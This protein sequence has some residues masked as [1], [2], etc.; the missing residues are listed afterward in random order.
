[1]GLIHPSDDGARAALRPPDELPE[2]HSALAW[3]DRPG[4]ASTT[5]SAPNHDARTVD[6]SST[7]PP[8]GMKLEPPTAWNRAAHQAAGKPVSSAMQMASSTLISLVM[9]LSLLAAA[10][11]LVPSLVEDIRYRWYRGQLR[12][13]YELTDE[14]MRHVAPTPGRRLSDGRRC[15]RPAWCISICSAICKR[16]VSTNASWAAATLHS[17]MKG[18][19]AGS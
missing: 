14:R 16:S 9:V 4:L 8:A 11:L 6:S 3:D 18:K 12:A 1:M 17:A 7:V 10:R 13:E 19:A 5:A 15:L 2:A